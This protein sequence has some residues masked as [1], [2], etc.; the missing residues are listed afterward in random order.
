VGFKISTEMQ[1][2]DDAE[3]FHL[4]FNVG[5]WNIIASSSGFEI[6]DVH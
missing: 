3:P 1:Q 4:S 6:S 2:V 5:K